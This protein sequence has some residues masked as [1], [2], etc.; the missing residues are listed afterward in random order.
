MP[1]TPR[2]LSSY[3]ELT[4]TRVWRIDP[5]DRATA[6]SVRMASSRTVTVLA[7]GR[8]EVYRAKVD[9]GLPGRH[10]I[11]GRWL[12]HQRS[13]RAE[14][15]VRR[16]VAAHQAKLAAWAKAEKDRAFQAFVRRLT[17]ELGA[18]RK[19]RACDRAQRAFRAPSDERCAA[20]IA[21]ARRSRAAAT[22]Y[23]APWGRELRVVAGRVGGLAAL[24]DWNIYGPGRLEPAL[25]ALDEA[26]GLTIDYIGD[27]E[28]FSLHLD[29]VP[30]R[31]ASH[32]KAITRG[33]GYGARS[34]RD[35]TTRLKA[36]AW[37]VGPPASAWARRWDF[38]R[39]PGAEDGLEDF[40]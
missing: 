20:L 25:D 31:P 22:L 19:A 40:R 37:I 11:A 32:G 39:D 24:F 6:Y 29:R 27:E 3:P 18:P 16:S 7:N 12:V 2:P 36:R 23:L 21:E 4:T 28:W 38:I 8:D 10:A 33:F 34:Q 1:R 13:P 35:I 17:K 5:Y 9:P 14:E 26:A 30:R 15:E